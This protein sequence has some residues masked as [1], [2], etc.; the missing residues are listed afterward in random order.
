[1]EFC[2]NGDYDKGFEKRWPWNSASPT[3]HR[4][5][6]TE[7]LEESW[8][9]RH[10]ETGIVTININKNICAESISSGGLGLVVKSLP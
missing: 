2:L 8:M 9:G 10:R 4:A 1:M 5:G 3:Q 6:G 7:Q